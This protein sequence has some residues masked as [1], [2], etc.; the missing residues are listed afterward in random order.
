MIFLVFCWLPPRIL[1][2]FP[3][4]FP[5]ISFWFSW[6]FAGY[7]LWFFKAF[8]L[9]C[10]YYFADY[11]FFTKDITWWKRLKHLVSRCNGGF[12]RARY[13][14]ANQNFE[15]LGS[16]GKSW[17]PTASV[18]FVTGGQLLPGHLPEI[19]RTSPGYVRNTCP[20]HFPEI[21]RTCSKQIS[22][23]FPGHFLLIFLVFR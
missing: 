20:G 17:V 15:V 16:P 6:Y 2:G 4:Q 14:E 11:R 21:P 13:N 22:R 1:P 10:S 3:G 12:K 5:D 23:T 7:P 19:S 18:Y 8:P 9:L